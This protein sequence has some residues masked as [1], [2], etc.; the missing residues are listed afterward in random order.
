[1]PDAITKAQYEDA[2][3]K[4]F[5]RTK[6]ILRKLGTDAS[7][8]EEIAQGAWTQGWARRHQ[9]I[10]PSRV[11]EWVTSIAINTLRT[12]AA[13]IRRMVALCAAGFEPKIAPTVNPVV[14][15]LHDALRHCPE[16]QRM[17]VEAVYL[18]GRTPNEVAAGLGIS[19]NAVHQRVSRARRA[20]RRAMTEL[21][22][23][24]HDRATR[25]PI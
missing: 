23:G 9:L 3:R 25:C 5:G 15:D 18:E 1:M 14:I 13:K 24:Y 12:E 8:A 2:Y 20:L 7:Q 6:A 22:N 10:D 16:R 19:T 4:G 17:I 21:P 11:V